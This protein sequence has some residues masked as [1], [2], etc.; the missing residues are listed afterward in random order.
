VPGTEVTGVTR[1]THHAHSDVPSH[2]NHVHS[3][4]LATLHHLHC[5]CMQH[6]QLCSL[7][8]VHPSS[9]K[10][11]PKEMFQDF[12]RKNNRQEALS[13]MQLTVSTIFTVLQLARYKILH[14]Y[15][16]LPALKSFD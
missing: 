6:F 12:S 11:L 8:V 16:C 10:N 13:Y 4:V 3:N 9:L 5:N 1:P 14:C 7:Q 15:K 2:S